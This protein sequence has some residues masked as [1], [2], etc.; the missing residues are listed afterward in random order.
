VFVISV[1]GLVATTALVASEENSSYLEA[2]AVAMR[3]LPSGN[4]EENNGDI[5]QNMLDSGRNLTVVAGP[6]FYWI[7]QYVFDKHDYDYRTQY[8]L[9]STKTLNNILKGSEKV[10]MVADPGILEVVNKERMPD[11]E[12]AKLRAER[13]SEI[14]NS[15][16]LVV[17]LGTVEI[18][19]NYN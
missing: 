18:R 2:A 7:M 3:H 1:F 6:G 8:S 14:Y 12:R 4:P 15:T 13:L 17:K 16:K 5:N 9:I 19:T 11:N 10:L